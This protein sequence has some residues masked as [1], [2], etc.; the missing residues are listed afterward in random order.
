MTTLSATQRSSMY[1]IHGGSHALKFPY[2]QSPLT[3]L[4]TLS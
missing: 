2:I 3:L 4:A 1:R